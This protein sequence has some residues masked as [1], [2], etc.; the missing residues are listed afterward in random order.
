MIQEK[1]IWRFPASRKRELSEF[2]DLTLLCNKCQYCRYVYTPEARNS[3]FVN[4]CPRGDVFKYPS[5]YAEGT[6]EIARAIIEGK[7][8]WSKEIE[9]I[10]YTCT[11]CGY[12]EYSCNL[13]MRAHPLTIMEVM[14]EQYVKEV[15]LPDYWKPIVE[16]L[17]KYH[18]PYGE[19]AEKRFDWLP[20][21]LRIPRKSEIVLFVGDVYAYRAR[22]VAAA[23]IRILKKLGVD[24]GLLYDDEWH[25]GYLHFR[26]GLREKGVEFLKHNVK[27]LEEAGAKKVV[28]LDPYD[29]RTFIKELSE[30][31]MEVKFEVVHFLDFVEPLL[32]KNSHRLK[33]LGLK[34]T[35][36][37]PC[38]LT[39]NVMPFPV[40]NSPRHILNMIGIEVAEMPRK[41]LNTY[42]S[43]A[44]GGVNFTFPKLTEEIARRRLE[45]A[46]ST[47]ASTL[48]TSSPSSI[49]AFKTQAHLFKI[50][51]VD[52]LSLIDKSLSH[53]EVW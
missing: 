18:N 33:K 35:Y 12:C 23:A 26:A 6:L 13:S 1:S 53:E 37:D 47:G 14:K 46:A 17:E 9:H 29:Y 19:P 42:C 5:Y 11:D 4:Q 39:R 32:E 10:L 44:G 2:Y 20:Q 43:G 28:F 24:F 22:E 34:V 16:N 50:D 21:E 48:V 40:W 36:H 38:N 41:M 30:E 27:A 31:G 52:I 51:I 25:S 3:K 45:E 8:S 49:E 15:G 7:L